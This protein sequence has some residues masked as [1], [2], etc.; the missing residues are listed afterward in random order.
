MKFPLTTH[1]HCFCIT[2]TVEASFMITAVILSKFSQQED[3]YTEELFSSPTA[4][5]LKKKI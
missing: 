1:K 2:S 3:S 4:E 5:D